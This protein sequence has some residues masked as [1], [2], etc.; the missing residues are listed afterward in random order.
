[1]AD[2]RYTVK[3]KIVDNETKKTADIMLNGEDPEKIGD[4]LGSLIKASCDLINLNKEELEDVKEM[5]ET[6]LK[7]K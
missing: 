1:M 6:L 4:S 2:H 3:V 7:K 5:V